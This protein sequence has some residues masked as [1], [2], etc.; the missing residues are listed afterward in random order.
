MA[1]SNNEGQEGTPARNSEKSSC[2]ACQKPDSWSNLVQCDNCQSWWHQLCA[3]VTGSIAHRRWSCRNCIPA[4]SESSLLTTSSILNRRKK[5]QLQLLQEQRAL[6]R[7]ARK[8]REKA[9]E[10]RLKSQLE[11]IQA[12]K[13]YIDGKFKLL[14]EDH[15]SD[16]EEEVRSLISHRSRRKRIE[17]WVEN[18]S[19]R[20][21]PV[22]VQLGIMEPEKDKQ[23]QSSGAI[24]PDASEAHPKQFTPRRSTGTIPKLSVAHPPVFNQPQIDISPMHPAVARGTG[25]ILSTPAGMDTSRSQVQDHVTNDKQ[26][27]LPSEMIQQVPGKT[28]PIIHPHDQNTL[29]CQ[30]SEPLSHLIQQLGLGPNEHINFT[31]LLPAYQPTPSQLAARQVMNRDLPTF[32][33]SPAEWPIFISTF[34]NTTL[35]CGFSPA[36]NLVRL[37][38]CLKGP[39]L[40]AVRSDLLQPECVPQIMET[41]RFVYGR[42]ELLLEELLEKIRGIPAPKPDRLET[43]VDYGVAVKSLSGHLEAAHLH[44]HLSNPTLLSELVNRLPAHVM[45]DWA[46]HCKGLSEVNLKTFGAFM[47]NVARTVSQVC[48]SSGVAV[49]KETNKIKRGTVHAHTELPPERYHPGKRCP[50]CAGQH[51]LRDCEDFILSNIEERWNLINSTQICRIC[52]FAHGKRSCRS[53]NKCGISGC[54]YRHHTLL[55]TPSSSPN[56]PHPS[57]TVRDSGRSQSGMQNQTPITVQPAASGEILSHRSS[58]RGSLFRIIPITVYGNGK[59]IDTVAF[60]DEGSSL[61]LIEESLVNE[62]NIKGT[63]QALCLQWTGNMSRIEKDSEIVDLVISGIN[64]QKTNMKETRTVKRLSLPTQTLDYEY[65]ANKYRHLKGLPVGS[66]VNAVP[67]ILIGVN[68][69]HLTVPLRVKEGQSDEPK[70][71]KTRLGWCIYGGAKSESNIPSISFHACECLKDETLHSMVRNFISQEDAGLTTEITL[72][73]EADKR[74]RSILEETTHRIG[75]RFSTRLLWRFD[76]FELPDSYPMAVKRMECLERKMAKNPRL[77]ENLKKQLEDYQAKGYAHLAT[78]T[79][80]RNSDPRRTWYLPLGV[81]VNPKKPE[82]VRMIWDASAT[83][84]GISLNTMLLKGPDELIPLPWILFRFRQYPV[85]VT[86]DISEMFHQI[87]IDP[88]DQQAQRFLWRSDPRSSPE[89]YVMN[90]ATFGATCSPAAAQFVK[91]KNA[92]EFRNSYPRAVEGITQR[93]YVDDYAD[94]FETSEEATRV[95]SE[96]RLIH[97]AGG[98]NI[99]GWRSNDTNVLV[100]LGESTAQQSKTLDLELRSYERVLGMHWLPEEDVLGYSTTLPQELH[101]I[102]KLRNRPTKRQVLRCLMS[103]FDPLGLLAAFILHGKVLLQDI[104]R[105]GIEWD[106]VIVDEA[107]EKW[108]RWTDQFEH[109]SKLRIPRCYFD[110]V[111]RVHYQQMELHIFVDAS[112]DAYAAA[113]YFRIPSGP[114]M[115]ECTLVAAKNKVAPLKHWSIPRLELQA[116][117]TGARLRKFISDGHSVAAQRVVYWSDSSTVLAWI[118]SDHRRFSQFVACR[119]GEILSSTNVSEW[120]WVPSRFNVADHATKWGQGPPLWS[121]DTWFKGPN[122]L[123]G[124][125]EDWPQPKIP[126]TTTEELRVSC[127]HSAV[128][129]MESV[130]TFTNFSKWERLVRTMAY[131][132]RYGNTTIVTRRQSSTKF[133]NTSSLHS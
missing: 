61:T 68:N 114:G 77:L 67:R 8:V 122:F 86:A 57:S 30:Q 95:S 125:E 11:E 110:K 33:G 54:N 25:R 14:Q 21:D 89:I 74:A 6:D 27:S 103:F 121:D 116:A 130:V 53:Q 106:E 101:D 80:L 32:T 108:Q 17:T 87:M 70:A 84:N 124:P 48:P 109:V 29:P 128:V 59:S 88:V 129:A 99:R 75:E 28:V 23:Q 35:N 131:V 45:Y 36:E 60:I 46:K 16:K 56:P 44:E 97:A 71:A 22:S 3:G 104:W 126:K 10:D 111:T 2:V 41:L 127:V 64:Q 42:P 39:A 102:I 31:H 132:Y 5:L 52:L 123:W 49:K 38:R 50:K 120:R 62:L 107:F 96:V 12:E 98:F 69:L 51:Y 47:N 91:N 113:G 40:E 85:A 94:S 118:R 105:S 79:E 117:V 83:V 65:L 82:K 26:C 20:D 9:R 133:V 90:V 78:E 72:E 19:R 4:I 63:P 92:R 115:F 13:D 119:V 73:S 24:Q 58:E 7:R 112:E 34:I 43:L 100:S 93:H 76:E 1:G 66:Y 37:Q 81:V 55:H 15:I 18:S